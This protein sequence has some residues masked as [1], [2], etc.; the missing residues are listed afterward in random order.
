MTNATAEERIVIPV[1]GMTCAACQARVQR[2]LTRTPGVSDANVNLMLNNAT[3]SFDP[4]AISADKLVE[5]IRDSGYGAELPATS[6]GAFAEQEEAEAAHAKEVRAL[7]QKV[8]V[9]MV[10]AAAAMALS[11]Q[12]AAGAQD[13]IVRWLLLVLTTFVMA[14][15]GRQFYTRAWSALKHGGSDMNTLISVGT[16]AAYLFSVAATIAPSAFLARGVEPHVYFEAVD[17]IIALILLG[18]LFEARAKQRTSAALRALAD[19]QPHN[20]RVVVDGQ[21]L[22]V[23]VEQVR[24]GD[25]VLIRP[26]ER[27]P[28]DGDVIS[29]QS[30]VDESM[31][32]GES[33]P[34]AKAPDGKVYGGTMNRTGALRIRATALGADSALARIVQLMR[35]AQGT[36]APIQNLADRVSSI[37]VPTVMGIAILTFCLWLFLPQHAAG[38]QLVVHALTAAVAVLIIACPCAMGLAVPTAMMVA[39][40][41]GAH[42][43]ILFKGG[44]ALQR[45]NDIDVVVLDKTGTVTEGRPTVTDIVPFGDKFTDDALLA[46]VASVE[47]QSEHPLADAIVQS[48]KA[49][50]LALSDAEGFTALAGHGVTAVVN[51]SALAIGNEALMKQYAVDVAPLRDKANALAGDAKTPAYVAV[52]GELAGLIAVADPIK[53]TTV[54]AVHALGALGAEVVLLT[55]DTRRTADAIARQAGIGRV[56]AEVLP[57][58]KV[59]AIRK[60]QAEGHV[61]GMVGDGINDAPALAQADV[62]FA[63]GT[64]A[65]VAI[66]AGGVTLMRGDPRGVAQAMQLAR[67]TMGTMKQNLFWAFIYNVIGIPIAAGALYPAF[68]LQLNPV[69]ASGAMAFSSVSVVSNSLRLRRVKIS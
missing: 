12:G 55:G 30:A 23:P 14:W 59:D 9:A 27:V 69:I 65:D 40:G 62:G 22:D 44:D 57:E 6:R 25:T 4:Q 66:E 15:A 3:I 36:R 51:G 43:G 11:M 58:G 18:N 60:L 67:K 52:D 7:T 61:V 8:V 45:A 35:D 32:S 37:F 29:G 34:V 63:I 48:A 46:L 64:G 42:L 39:T 19:L 1:T 21:E 31:L 54:E 10:L 5:A 13:T 47:R 33:M 28:V 38:G 2:T 41:R 68:G 53:Q 49:R 24:R 20:A 50:E 17:A 26:G 56:I 16:G